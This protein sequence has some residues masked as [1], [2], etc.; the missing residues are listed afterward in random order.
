MKSQPAL[1]GWSDFLHWVLHYPVKFVQIQV[2]VFLVMTPCY[3]V[4]GYRRFGGSR[5]SYGGSTK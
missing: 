1:L 2:S 5:W 4:V 3:D